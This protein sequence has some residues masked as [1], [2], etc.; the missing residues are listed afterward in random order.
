VARG[1]MLNKRIS[2]D[3][4][5]S[6][7][8]REVGCCGGLFFTWCIAHL[9]RDG[10]IDG[11][12]EVLRGLVCPRLTECSAELIETTISAAARRGL[13]IWY[14]S[15]GERFLCFPG[16]RKNQL[17]LPYDKE[18]TSE[19]PDPEI[20][21]NVKLRNKQEKRREVK[22][23]KEKRSEEKRRED[24]TPNRDFAS[25]S[26]SSA[27]A[28][29]NNQVDSVLDVWEHW[30]N[31]HPRAVKK[32][33]SKMKSYRL[34][35]D[36]LKEGRSAE[37]LKQAIDGLH[38]DPWPERSNHLQIKYALKDDDTVTKFIGFAVNPRRHKSVTKAGQELQAMLE[39]PLD[40]FK[41]V[42]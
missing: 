20:C 21:N 25:L 24:I 42:L 27:P 3:K 23:S 26:A 2:R 29:I 10:R 38:L 33:T 5:V 6:E 40:L 35:R 8:I 39:V 34:I 12:P 4:E 41:D 9:D 31:H 7:L 14:E 13:V 22:R 19:F 18:P 28:P 37:D 30:R 15:N 1:R 11:D 17:N 32:L 16:F 36:R